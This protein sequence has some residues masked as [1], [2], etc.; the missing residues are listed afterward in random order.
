[1]LLLVGN[2]AERAKP[3]FVVCA[4]AGG[5]GDVDGTGLNA[6]FNYPTGIEVDDIGNIYVADSKNHKIRKINSTLEV[7][8]FAG[9]GSAG[10]VDATG[11]N[12]SF[13]KPRGLALDNDGNV[14]VADHENHKI[15]KITPSGDVTTYAGS[16]VGGYANGSHDVAKFN[17]PTGVVVDNLGNVY[18]A[19]QFNHRVRKINQDQTVSTLAG[20]GNLTFNDGLGEVASFH[21]PEKLALDSSGD[22]LVADYFNERIRKVTLQKIELIGDSS[23]QA[24]DHIVVLEVDDG[25]GGITF[26][27]FTINVSGSTAGTSDFNLNEDFYVYPNPVSNILKISNK[28]NIEIKDIYLYDIVGKVMKIENSNDSI[29]LNQISNGVYMIK[30]ITEKGTGTLKIIKK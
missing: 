15:R 28:K 12:S 27:N 10:S 19:D 4:L 24:G 3:Q 17:F 30:I 29:N 22:L 16:G 6:K 5:F 7:T 9:S 1:M 8:T 23:G 26:Q 14:Y 2:G 11:T 13:K 18:V 25:N 21:Y 20:S